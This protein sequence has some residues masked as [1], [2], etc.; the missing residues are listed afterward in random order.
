MHISDNKEN[1]ADGYEDSLKHLPARQ[2]KR[3]LDGD[4]AEEV[5]GALWNRGDDSEDKGQ[6]IPRNA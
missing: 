3:F 1:V 4:F 2:R 6:V 5:M